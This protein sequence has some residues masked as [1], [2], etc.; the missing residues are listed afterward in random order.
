M[1]ETILRMYQQFNALY[2]EYEPC[3]M[4]IIS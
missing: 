1:I 2:G 4:N 3:E